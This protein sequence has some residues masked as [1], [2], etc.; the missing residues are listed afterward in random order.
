MLSFREQIYEEHIF[1]GNVFYYGILYTNLST[2]MVQTI[3]SLFVCHTYYLQTL[4]M[5]KYFF[6]SLQKYGPSRKHLRL[7]SGYFYKNIIFYL[8]YFYK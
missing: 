4:R 8:N 6:S 1:A 7:F 2:D 3:F 5:F